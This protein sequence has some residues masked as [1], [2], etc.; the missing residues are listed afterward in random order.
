MI[1]PSATVFDREWLSLLT[2]CTDQ[3]PR[4]GVNR[5][6]MSRLT[7]EVPQVRYIMQELRLVRGSSKV[8]E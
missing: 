1:H 3:G 5:E 7:P 2:S 4:L 6:P 8:V